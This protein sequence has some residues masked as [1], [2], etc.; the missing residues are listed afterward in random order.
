MNFVQAIQSG[1]KNYANFRGVAGRPEYWYFYLFTYLVNLV[2]STL[3][4]VIASAS[5]QQTSML[6]MSQGWLSTLAS[7]VLVIPG[8]SMTVRRIRDSGHTQKWW[9]LHII[10]FVLAVVGLGFFFAAVA[11]NQAGSYFNYFSQFDSVG[12]GSSVDGLLSAIVMLLVY[13]APALIASL[14]IGIW[15]LVMTLQPTKTA[16]QGNKYVAAYGY[17]VPQA[18]SQS[19]DY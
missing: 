17:Q 5:G 12:L 10:P 1:F 11:T 2:T 19:T 16:E 13:L 4:S 9:L 18:R 15:F 6:E 8:L 3:D 7:L 14:G